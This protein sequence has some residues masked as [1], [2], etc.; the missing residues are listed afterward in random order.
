MLLEEAGAQGPT[1]NELLKTPQQM[2]MEQTG[3]PQQYADGG[4]VFNTESPSSLPNVSFDTRSIPSI[5]G[6]PGVGYMETPQ[7]TMARMQLEKE[8]EN[9]ARIRAGVSGMGIALPGQHGVKLMPGQMDAGVN[10]PVGR[11]HLDISANRSINPIPGRGHMQGVNARYSIPFAEGGRTEMSPQ[12]MLA[13][14]VVYGQEPQ[15]FRKGGHSLSGMLKELKAH[16][17]Q[18]LYNL[19]GFSDVLEQGYNAAKHAHEGKPVHALESGFN[20]AAAIPSA[21]PGVPIA[22]SLA[23]PYGGQAITEQAANYMAQQPEYRN[24]MMDMSSSPLGGMLGGDS[25]LAAHIM[26]NRDYSDV[27]QNRMPPETIEEEEAQRPKSLLY[28]KT[29]GIK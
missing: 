6:M 5:S 27:L 7:G 19:F 12:D 2:L 22:A 1:S 24:Q 18:S 16:P 11:G 3:I 29:M 9:K 8:L 26:G 4:N 14:M 13:E 21:L 28:Q 10:M 17:K 25:A 23:V 20:A 15:H